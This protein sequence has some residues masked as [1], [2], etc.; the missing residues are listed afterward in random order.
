MAA[1]PAGSAAKVAAW[2]DEFLDGG[3]VVDQNGGM[4]QRRPR[5]EVGLQVGVPERTRKSGDWR[6]TRPL[7]ASAAI[8]SS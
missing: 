8:Q 2:N 3:L 4:P 6:C 5:R 1:R 7:R